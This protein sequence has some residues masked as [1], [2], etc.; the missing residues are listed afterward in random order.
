MLSHDSKAPQRATAAT[1]DS[2]CGFS[3]SGMTHDYHTVRA[4]RKPR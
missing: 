2:S 3:T 4:R 1:L